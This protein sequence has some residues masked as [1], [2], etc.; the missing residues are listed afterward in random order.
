MVRMTA[1][2]ADGRGLRDD[3]GPLMPANRTLIAINYL[4]FASGIR[5]PSACISGFDLSIAWQ[6]DGGE[7]VFENWRF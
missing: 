3:F 4:Q 5:V 7:M 2:F 1:D 6:V